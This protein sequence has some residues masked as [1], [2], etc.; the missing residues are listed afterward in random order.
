MIDGVLVLTPPLCQSF[1]SEP[2]V[3]CATDYYF[4]EADRQFY[5]YL[6]A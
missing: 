4:Y 1:T 6:P 2:V 5:C 3:A